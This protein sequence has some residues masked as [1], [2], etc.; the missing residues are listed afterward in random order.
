MEGNIKFIRYTV[1]KIRI[2]TLVKENIYD[3]LGKKGE[4]SIPRNVT[5]KGPW[6]SPSIRLVVQCVDC[7]G[8]R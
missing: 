6:N 8:S 1:I 7:F 2:N 3:I 5:W 4:R